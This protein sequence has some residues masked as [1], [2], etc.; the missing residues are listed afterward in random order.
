MSHNRTMPLLI[1]LHTVVILGI[2]EQAGVRVD[3]FLLFCF[4]PSGVMSRKGYVILYANCPIIWCI[5]Q[6]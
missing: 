6:K 4:E 2:N 5:K 3:R 1:T